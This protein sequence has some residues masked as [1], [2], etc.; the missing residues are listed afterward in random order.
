MTTT[1]TATIQGEPEN[2]RDASVCAVRFA[3]TR[4]FAD[5]RLTVRYICETEDYEAA[6]TQAM[7]NIDLEQVERFD[8]ELVSI[9]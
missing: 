1:I 2:L 5:H 6:L 3:S 4:R 7:E 9:G 8:C